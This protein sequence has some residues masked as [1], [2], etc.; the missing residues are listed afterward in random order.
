MSEGIWVQQ[1]AVAVAA[2][3]EEEEAENKYIQPEEEEEAEDKYIQEA[4][5]DKYTQSEE[6]AAV[7]EGP[8]AEAVQAESAECTCTQ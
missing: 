2:E 3:A 7:P 4:M 1:E 8:A 5:E 6:G